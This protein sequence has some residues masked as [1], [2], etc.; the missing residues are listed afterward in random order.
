M[1]AIARE[2]DVNV[3]RERHSALLSRTNGHTRERTEERGFDEAALWLSTASRD[4]STAL[5]APRFPAVGSSSTSAHARLG[6]PLWL[7]GWPAEELEPLERALDLHPGHEQATRP[8][9]QPRR[10]PR[11]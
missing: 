6:E 9:E 1:L 10:A 5:G 11:G 3:A 2:H 4:S 7:A 8:H